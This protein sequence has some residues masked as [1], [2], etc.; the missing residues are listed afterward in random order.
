MNVDYILDIVKI[1]ND[2]VGSLIDIIKTTSDS[3]IREAAILA[4]IDNFKDSKIIPILKE[5]IDSPKLSNYNAFIV[6]ALGEYS[7]C[8]ED[9]FFLT[10][11]VINKDYHAALNAYNIITEMHQP[12]DKEALEESINKIKSLEQISA[13]RKDI[14]NELLLFLTF[15]LEE[16]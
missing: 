15:Y 12:F 11:L 9:L 2:A 8:K 3:K 4:L 10:E 5:L 14:V 13:E 1:K 6:Y 16:S 7:D